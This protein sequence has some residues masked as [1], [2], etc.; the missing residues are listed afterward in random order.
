MLQA[1][2]GS[3]NLFAQPC[4]HHSS[5]RSDLFYGLEVWVGQ[6]GP[7][8]GVAEIKEEL[9]GG[10]HCLFTN[11]PP[12]ACQVPNPVFLPSDSTLSLLT[13]PM[14]Q[15]SALS[16]PQGPSLQPLPWPQPPVAHASLHPQGPRADLPT[17]LP[18]LPSTPPDTTQTLDLASKA[19]HGL[20]PNHTCCSSNA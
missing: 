14:A 5:S 10:G 7:E 15:A 18:W 9:A 17:A 13:C 3:Q 12:T 16:S 20:A 4:L 8:E 6:R 11:P 19:L 1:F 2:L